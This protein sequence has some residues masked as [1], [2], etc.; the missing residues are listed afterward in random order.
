MQVPNGRMT[1]EETPPGAIRT[2]I[3]LWLVEFMS[4]FDRVQIPTLLQQIKAEFGLTDAQLGLLSGTAFG[5]TYAMAAI[6]LAWL[7]DRYS[8]RRLLAA[9]LALWATMTALSGAARSLGG[10]LLARMGVAGGEAAFT[11]AAHSILA[12]VFPPSRLGWAIGLETTGGTLGLMT[13]MAVAGLVS[14]AYGWRAAMVVASVPALFMAVAVLSFLRDPPRSGRAA[15]APG[16]DAPA[17][18]SLLGRRYFTLVVLAVLNSIMSTGWAQ[19]LP[20][21]FQRSHGMPIGR[22]GLAVGLATGMGLMLGSITGGYASKAAARR[23]P[24]APFLFCSVVCM[25]AAPSLL[26]TLWVP[27]TAA[28]LVLVAISASL[29]GTLA[30]FIFSNI[31]AICNPAGR[32]RAVAVA[33]TIVTVGSYALMPPLV[34]ALSDALR[35]RLGID[36]LRGALTFLVIA[37][38]AAALIFRRL[39]TTAT[40]G[41]SGVDLAP[42]DG[43]SG[44]R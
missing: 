38:C 43:S 24:G 12:D 7:A 31:Q 3:I 4:L 30:P 27:A 23:S 25:L 11:P 29:V 44:A 18:F 28:A 32:A 22:V 33:M 42:M 35:P 9:A 6:P 8:R 1:A 21:F 16:R 40:G 39:A 14:A 37:P 26:L 17:S 41:R 36:A 2:L 34:G 19:W 15:P 10:L 5:I 20:S 13:G